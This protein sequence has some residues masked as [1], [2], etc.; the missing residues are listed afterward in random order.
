MK[1]KTDKNGVEYIVFSYRIPVD[2]YE[3]IKKLAKKNKRSINAEIDMAIDT[4]VESNE[5]EK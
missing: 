4:Y 2:K 3:S 1:T 5:K